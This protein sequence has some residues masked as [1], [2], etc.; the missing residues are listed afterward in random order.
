MAAIPEYG[1]THWPPAIRRY[2]YGC[3]A[4]DWPTIFRPMPYISHV[5]ATGWYCENRVSQYEEPTQPDY[6]PPD[7][8]DVADEIARVP[9]LATLAFRKWLYDEP[10]YGARAMRT[11][12][13]QEQLVQGQLG[14]LVILNGPGDSMRS[15]LVW[16]ILAE[17]GHGS[18]YAKHLLSHAP[19]IR[20]C[21]SKCTDRFLLI[22]LDQLQRCLVG[23]L[24]SI[25]R[26]ETKSC[27][28]LHREP[29]WVQF[30]LKC[31][32]FMTTEDLDQSL[33]LGLSGALPTSSTLSSGAAYKDM[34]YRA[35]N[36]RA[37]CV[38]LRG[39]QSTS[40]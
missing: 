15:D 18:E 29:M 5:V 35:L 40:N 2:M 26:G 13:R 10:V 38:L 23:L 16:D 9:S 37:D 20:E 30:P 17:T 32:I 21:D 7:A 22:R 14:C 1:T 8:D 36:M 33:R 12:L 34:L 39:A 25:C 28:E 27:R 3:M 11:F 4:K 19:I 24:N 31:I 6:G